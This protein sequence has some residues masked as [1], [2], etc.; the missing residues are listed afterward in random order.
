L[1]ND[2][3]DPY[4]V[5]QQ[6]EAD[7]LFVIEDVAI[8]VEVKGKPV[9][10]A[11]R[12]GDVERLSRDFEDMAG[13]AATQAWRLEELIEANGGLWLED[14]TWLD[15]SQ[16]QETRSIAV[17]LDDVGPL[18]VALHQLQEAGIIKPARPPWV[19]SLHDLI[20]I[21]SICDRPSEFLLYLRRRSDSDVARLY[22]GVDELD[23]YMLFLDGGLYVEPDPDT[24]RQAHPATPPV[25]THDR[26]RR[27]ASAITS[28][29]GTHTDPLDAWMNHENLP[30]W[31]AAEIEK[32]S[33]RSEADLTALVDFLAE[34][35][36]PGWF[37]ISAD[38]LSLE[39]PAQRRVVAAM[40]KVAR[41][42]RQDKKPH[43]A[44]MGFAG[45][46]GYPTLFFGSYPKGW[47]RR[48]VLDK[49][50]LYARAKR[51][52]VQSDRSLVVLVSSAGDI[53]TVVYFPKPPEPDADLEEAGQQMGLQPVG[54]KSRVVPPSATRA[55]R[56][57]RGKRPKKRRR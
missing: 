1:H 46:W 27:E 33:F 45:T 11:G 21:S 57:L 53:K 44:V 6:T 40:R 20:T 43:Q 30:E 17:L 10:E 3:A 50:V 16:I 15:L 52:Q 37:R 49:L 48:E 2:C 41:D 29:V 24:V 25:T 51:L 47:D 28:R 14:K 56:Q 5:G 55:T 8:C 31:M 35:E 22:H 26:R 54:D 42:A 38:L 32:P 12:R 18:G 9:S 34:G 39:G 4:V 13:D 19:V 23:L 7:A 36:K